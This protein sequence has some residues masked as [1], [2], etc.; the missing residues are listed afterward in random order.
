M[1]GWFC[2]WKH[3]DFQLAKTKDAADSY[4]HLEC[5]HLRAL[6]QAS[7]VFQNINYKLFLLSSAH[8]ALLSL[9][10][11]LFFTSLL[12]LWSCACRSWN[13][14][15]WLVCSSVVWMQHISFPSMLSPAFYSLYPFSLL[16]PVCSCRF[17]QR[18]GNTHSKLS[19]HDN[20]KQHTRP[21]TISPAWQPR[22]PWNQA[23]ANQT[24]NIYLL[25]F[26]S[27]DSEC[28]MQSDVEPCGV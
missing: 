17:T 24:P 18:L 27:P 9:S 3:D 7:F 11:S 12:W 8:S 26:S 4:F 14:G 21:S 28:N 13:T 2:E 1:S 16:R 10:V 20:T 5:Y 22:P 6:C 25:L 15:L 23:Q 19:L